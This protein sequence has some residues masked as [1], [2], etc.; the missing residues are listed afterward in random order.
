MDCNNTNLKR[1]ST[2]EQVREVQTLLQRKGYYTGRID[3]DY[4]T[5]TEEAVKKYQKDNRLTSD[6]WV[7]PVTCKKL[8]GNTTTPNNAVASNGN[9][10]GI[11]K[12][13]NHHE[14]RGCNKKGQCTKTYCGPH[15]IRQSNSKLD[16]DQFYESN[17]AGWAGTTSGGTSHGGLETAIYELGRRSGYNIKVEWKNFSDF[18]TTLTERFRRIGEI[19]E[20]QNKSVIWHNLY[21]NK[22]GHYEV[23]KVININNQTCTVLNS[24]GNSCGNG[25]Y[26]G[27]DEVR[28]FKEMASYLAGISQK[29]IMI[30]T[31]TK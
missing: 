13:R 17:I 5:Y 28:S 10:T 6:G 12:S 31:Y 22:Y 4:G 1:G 24:L 3:G 26:C 25:T 18:G 20:Q 16:I 21:R 14:G 8:Q 15:S 19:I 7:G 2:G 23:V 9:T 30:L 11:Y 27:Y 29:S